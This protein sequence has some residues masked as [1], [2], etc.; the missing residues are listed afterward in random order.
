MDELELRPRSR[1]KIQPAG[2]RQNAAM[3]GYR[4][5]L[6][7][8]DFIVNGVSLGDLCHVDERDLVGMLTPESLRTKF[9]RAKAFNPFARAGR[10]PLELG[11]AVPCSYEGRRVHIYGC[12]E[13]GDLYCGSV[14]MQLIETESTV[15][16]RAF[17]D[18]REKLAFNAGDDKSLLG[19][20]LLDLWQA[21]GRNYGILQA[22]ELSE[23]QFDFE[24]IS[25]YKAG[26]VKVEPDADLRNSVISEP[27]YPQI[28]P[29]EFEKT[30]YLR[31]FRT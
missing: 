15:I 11:L 22:Y 3:D 25:A 4:R 20:D 14:T 19:T 23:Y 13:C 16:W 9:D 6:E 10:L 18:G 30:G 21:E 7:Y 12:P 8:L 29:F 5:P 31:L 27:E 17:D 24:F 2:A 1:L 28:G 26:E